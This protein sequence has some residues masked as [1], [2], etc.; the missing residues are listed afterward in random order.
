MFTTSSCR[1]YLWRSP[2]RAHWQRAR[3]RLARER[4]GER[5][6]ARAR[7]ARVVVSGLGERALRGSAHR[8]QR[9]HADPAPRSSRSCKR[10]RRAC[11]RPARST[12]LIFDAAGVP[13]SACADG[14]TRAALLHVA[15]EAVTNAAK[16]GQPEHDR[17]DA[18]LQ[19]RLAPDRARRGRGI[20]RRQPPTTASVS[21]ACAP[22]RRRSAASCTSPAQPSEAPRWRWF[23]RERRTHRSRPQR[24]AATR[25]GTPE[26]PPRTTDAR[27]HTDGDA[28][29]VGNRRRPPRDPP[30]RAH[31]A[32]DRR[33]AG[34]RRGRRPR[35][36]RRGGAARAPPISA[37]ST[38]TCPA[39]ASRP[40]PRWPRSRPRPRW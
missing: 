7:G 4:R 22:T 32:D 18:A 11:R 9:A 21:P 26:T 31:G 19:R 6:R 33:P 13:R 12:R 16:H 34:A 2:T 28:P 30:G 27:A 1:I 20:R 23:C 10:S 35:R 40:P 5:G 38:S 39:G 17:G 8:S 3:E 25:A 36:R 29:T 14:S 15:R 24:R 37:C